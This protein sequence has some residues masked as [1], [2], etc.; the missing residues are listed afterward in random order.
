MRDIIRFDY[1]IV[2][3]R[4]IY[5]IPD[6]QSVVNVFSWETLDLRPHYPRIQRFLD[7]WRREV[8]AV[9]KEIMIC[10]SGRSIKPDWRQGIIIPHNE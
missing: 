5:Y 9:I 4:V 3:I 6:Y 2:T 8:E 1:S 10:D 7:H